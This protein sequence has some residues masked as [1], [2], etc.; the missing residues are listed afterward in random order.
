M[1]DKER[2]TQVDVAK[3]RCP[4]LVV[5]GT[6]DKVISAV[7]GRKIAQ[8]YKGATFREAEGRGHFLIQEQGAH[9][10]AQD[11]ADWLADA[12]SQHSGNA[13]AEPS[14]K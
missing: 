6:H 5:A 13:L 10:L 7:S 4:V 1:F 14:R 8:L 11:C 2:A 9:D 12:L 3:V